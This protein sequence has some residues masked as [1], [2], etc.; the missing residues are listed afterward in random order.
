MPTCPVCKKNSCSIIGKGSTGAAICECSF[1]GWQFKHVETKKEDTNLSQESHEILARINKKNNTKSVKRKKVR[2][3][4]PTSKQGE[5][6]KTLMLAILFCCVPIINWPLDILGIFFHEI[7]HG[8]AILLSGGEI[9]EIE[10]GVNYG[11]IYHKHLSL[12]KD[13]L[14]GWAGY[15][16]AVFWGVLLYRVGLRASPGQ[17]FFFV[18]F[19][20]LLI[21]VSIVLWV[22][23]T[24]TVFTLLITYLVIAC[25]LI[26][27]TKR[28]W[29][30]RLG[31]FI[32]FV[33]MYLI[34]QAVASPFYLLQDNNLGD[35]GSLARLSNL[36][37]T[38]WVSQW[39]MIGFLG[40]WWTWC[41]TTKIKK[42]PAPVPVKQKSRRRRRVRVAPAY[43]I[44]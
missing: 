11:L 41:M 3:V 22:K 34:V 33:G 20:I 37:D 25:S 44:A 38:F 28:H 42:A 18:M 12:H 43:N 19:L 31:L 24:S 6:M 39:V 2:P 32:K 40:M 29:M 17:S 23:D 35:A 13:M 36:P 26:F 16:G 30:K 4:H 1:C 10:V 14:A 5:F 7:S 9:T 27:L 15:T 21:G 8:I